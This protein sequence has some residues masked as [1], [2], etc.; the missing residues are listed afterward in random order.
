[1]TTTTH[2]SPFDTLEEV[3]HTLCSEPRP[4][5]L[6]PGA[7]P[8]LPGRAI[9]LDELQAILLHPSTPYRTRDAA[10][11]TLLA[12]A[13]EDREHW[14]V[15]LAGVLLPGLRRAVGVLCEVCPGKR[16]DVEAE[17]IAGLIEAVAATNPERQRLAS[18][19]VWLARNRAKRLVAAELSEV[20]RPGRE[21][22]SDAPAR[23]YGH[24][25]FVLA[26]AV[27]AGV[28]LAEDAA[29]IGDTRLGLLSITQAA[30]VLGLAPKGAYSRRTRAEVRLVAWLCHEGR[31]AENA[32]DSPYSPDGGRPRLGRSN[33]RPPAACQ[34]PSDPRR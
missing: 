12:R 11:R 24:P 10:I 22:T 4:L 26:E 34:P 21:P 17:A 30:A 9:P 25:D 1:M 2:A 16:A 3:F 29:L 19:L 13:Q 28:L 8:G 5:Q 15:G 7:V 6:P 33:D 20:A 31:F 32:A 23:P 14:L 27:A 18:R